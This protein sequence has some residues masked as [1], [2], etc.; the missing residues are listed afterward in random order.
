MKTIHSTSSD[1]PNLRQDG[2]ARGSHP[3]SGGDRYRPVP[4]GEFVR[5]D[6]PRRRWAVEG[7]W[8]EGTSGIIAG[9][10]KAGKSTISLE[11]AVTLSTGRPFLG[12]EPFP[13]SV[14]RARVTYIQAE[15][16]NHRVRRD[17]DHILE[18]RGLGFMD[19]VDNPYD[20]EGD[21]VGE[22][23]QPT[24]IDPEPDLQILSHPGMDL[25]RS[26]DQ[27]WLRGHA[28]NRDYVFFDPAYLL[29]S[30]NPNDTG[31]MMALL[32]LL[33]EIRDGAECAVILTHQMTDKHSGGDAASRMLGSTFLHGWYE[34]AIFAK[35]SSGGFFSLKTDGLREMGEERKIGAQGLGVGRW[36]F[37][38]EAQDATDSLDRDAPQT[39]AKA[40]KIAMLRELLD[41]HGDGWSSSQYATELGVSKATI[42][43][44]RA[45]IEDRDEE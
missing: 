26:E 10:P 19:P 45:E 35:R 12:L 25:M 37:T 40:T 42:S 28:A 21:P 30:A 31:Q 33:S 16:S 4:L 7:V 32:A 29:A 27:E 6:V 11:L 41:E 23:F 14:P 1:D 17:L 24:W 44:Y 8:A 36:Y 39:A 22:R 2:G 5:A 3:D 15:N 18:A 9:P 43:R 34:S 38:P 20:L 13:L